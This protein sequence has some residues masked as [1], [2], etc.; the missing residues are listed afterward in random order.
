M[1]DLM[2]LLFR[3][4]KGARLEVVSTHEKTKTPARRDDKTELPETLR[5]LCL[6]RVS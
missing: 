6:A 5:G 4:H 1:T 2:F 3:V